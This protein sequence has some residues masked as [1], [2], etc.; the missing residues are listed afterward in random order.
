MDDPSR[1]LLPRSF[2]PSSSTIMNTKKVSYI[3]GWCGKENEF[4]SR[5]ELNCIGCGYR[6]FYKKRIAGGAQYEAR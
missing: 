3:C 4:T 1:S 2:E 6:I 5:E